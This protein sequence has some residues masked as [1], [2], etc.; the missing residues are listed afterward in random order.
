MM[1]PEMAGPE[2]RFTASTEHCPHPERWS[3][4]D[5]DST[6]QEVI[7]LL[8]GLVRAL[9]PDACLETGTAFGEAAVSISDA[10][11]D[12]GH[13]HLYTLE[14]DPER[15][16]YARERLDRPTHC[17]TVIEGASLDWT[18]PEGIVFGFCYFDSYYPLRV[19]EFRHFRP[20]MHKGTIACFHDTA[21]SHGRASDEPGQDIRSTIA[22][23]LQKEIRMIHLPTPRG[24]TIGEVL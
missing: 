19:P 15:V 6:E 8:Y 5:P 20:F 2:S 24:I 18:P 9:Q 4:T 14:C 11:Y 13:G 22:T 17:A 21:P 7:D 23:Q 3:S 16:A 12:S 10:L 1:F